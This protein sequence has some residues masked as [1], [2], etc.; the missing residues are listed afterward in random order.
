VTITLPENY[1]V[2]ATGNCVTDSENAWMDSLA[3]A[4]LLSDTLY[5]KTT[6]ASSPRLKTIVFKEDNVHDFAW[7]A[8][9]RWMVRKDSILL[10]GTQSPIITWSAFL[11]SSAK[12][13]SDANRYLVETV[14]HYSKL[15]GNYPYKT[16]KAVEGD[17]HAGGGMEYPTIT[18]IDRGAGNMMLKRVLVHEAGHNWFYGILAS[19][20]RDHAGM[21]EGMNTFYEIKVMDATNE[22]KAATINNELIKSL[23]GM[24]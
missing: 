13:W 5:N 18:V 20:E 7:F 1:I 14:Q 19:N 9:K 23:S 2:M 4:P 10:P 11:P 16:I 15:V 24:E 8:D 12:I 22:K 21:D 6:P 3:A 17:M